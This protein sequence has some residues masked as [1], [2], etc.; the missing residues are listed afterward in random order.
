M[1]KNERPS[2]ENIKTGGPTVFQGSENPAPSGSGAQSPGQKNGKSPS[3]S[4]GQNQSQNPQAA[5]SK[6]NTEVSQ[7]KGRSNLPGTCW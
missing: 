7:D 5:R 6:G 2:G 1:N 4:A 3:S